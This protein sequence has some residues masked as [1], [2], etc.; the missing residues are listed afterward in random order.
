MFA[1]VIQ[2][3]TTRDKRA[4]MDALVTEG[5]IP[6][7]QEEPGFA[8][9][10]NL[11]DQDTG[12]EMMIVLWETEEQARLPASRRGLPYLRVLADITDLSTGI[13]SPISVWEVGVK[14]VH[15]GSSRRLA[16]EPSI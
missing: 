16:G 7:L 2:G 12:Q 13:R 14:V 11:V 3:G 15:T 8:G 1:Q 5:L 10:L 9:A 4:E 6:A